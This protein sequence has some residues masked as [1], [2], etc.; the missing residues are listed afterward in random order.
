MKILSAILLFDLGL[1]VWANGD[2]PPVPGEGAVNTNAPSVVAIDSNAVYQASLQPSPRVLMSDGQIVTW[3]VDAIEW[4]IEAPYYKV[5]WRAD[6]VKGEWITVA[7][8]TGN[9]A[10]HGSPEGFYRVIPIKRP[11]PPPTHPP[12]RHPTNDVHNLPVKLLD[13]SLNYGSI[14]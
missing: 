12:Q 14:R 7:Y 5:Q 3:T 2:F 8:R 1:L 4:H 13:V 9:R 10:A 6:L 11:T